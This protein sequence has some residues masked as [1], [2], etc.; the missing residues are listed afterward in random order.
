MKIIGKN[1]KRRKIIME[2]EINKDPTEILNPSETFLDSLEG[3]KKTNQN[4]NST[5]GE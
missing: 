4:N 3:K 5:S 2:A 1:V